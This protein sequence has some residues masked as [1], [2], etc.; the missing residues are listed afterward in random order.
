MAA[1]FGQIRAPAEGLVRRVAVGIIHRIHFDAFIGGLSNH[2]YEIEHR[3]L[4]F[5]IPDVVG[6]S[7]RSFVEHLDESRNRIHHITKSSRLV[8]RSV[9]MQG[10]AADNAAGEIRKYPV[11][12]LPHSRSVDIERTHDLAA[13]AEIFMVDPAKGLAQT[14][15]LV[16]AG[17]RTE[18]GDVAP[19]ALGRGNIAGLRIAVDFRGTE[20]QKLRLVRPGDL[21]H[22]LGSPN[23]D[24]ERFERVFAVVVRTRDAGGVENVVDGFGGVERLDDVVLDEGVALF[25]FGLLGARF[26]RRDQVIDG[27]QFAWT[28][29]YLLVEKA[30]NGRKVPSEK[31]APSR[32]KDRLALK[33]A[34]RFAKPFENLVN[35][36]IETEGFHFLDH[37]QFWKRNDKTPAGFGKRFMLGHNRLGKI[38][39][40]DQ[41]IIGTA[42]IGRRNGQNRN[43]ISGRI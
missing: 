26:A 27:D 30:E 15:A 20:K 40:Q 5:F 42:I 14:L 12:P 17:A 1:R 2:L 43:M 18:G 37:P 38:P 35:I 34:G 23:G 28:R 19:V 29:E 39:C 31:S 32:Q 7:G 9:H 22:V 16:V 36:P 41:K 4:G 8:A 6:L 24:L 3:Y 11:V 10:S 13:D 21:E 25:E 33:G